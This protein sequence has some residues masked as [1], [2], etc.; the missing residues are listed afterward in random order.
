MAVVDSRMEI[1]L[2]HAAIHLPFTMYL[3]QGNGKLFDIFQ[4]GSVYPD[5]RVCMR[6]LLLI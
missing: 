3:Q 6:S 4:P 1:S 5:E 2:L